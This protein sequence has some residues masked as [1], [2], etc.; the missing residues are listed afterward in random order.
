MTNVS[1]NSSCSLSGEYFMLAN[2]SFTDESN[3]VREDSIPAF[4]KCS[5]FSGS[6]NVNDANNNFRVGS[7]AT[8]NV[9]ASGFRY[10]NGTNLSSANITVIGAYVNQFGTMSPP[11]IYPTNSS[12]TM[13][14]TL[15][16][17]STVFSLYP[18]NFTV[19]NGRW[20][21]SEG[22]VDFKFRVCTG[23][24][25]SI[26][27]R[28]VMIDSSIR[29]WWSSMPG[30][31]QLVPGQPVTLTINAKTNVSN[32][33]GGF[34]SFGVMGSSTAFSVAGKLFDGW[35]SSSHDTA[36]NGYETWEVNVTVPA[37]LRKGGASIV[38]TINSSA[39]GSVGEKATIRTF[40]TTQG[41]TVGIT[42]GDMQMTNTDLRPTTTS[43]NVTLLS[44]GWNFTFIMNNLSGFSDIN[45]SSPVSFRNN[46]TLSSFGSMGQ[47]QVAVDANMSVLILIRNRSASSTHDTILLRNTSMGNSA[48]NISAFTVVNSTN[49]SFN[50]GGLYLWQI[51]SS[52]YLRLV[53]ANASNNGFMSMGI[54]QSTGVQFVIPYIVRQGNAPAVNASINITQIYRETDMGF[55]LG[56]PYTDYTIIAATTDS[57][58]VGF[59]T[60]NISQSG[61]YKLF[62]KVNGS[63]NES[64]SVSNQFMGG[65]GVTTGPTQINIRGFSVTMN[66]MADTLN[67]TVFNITNKSNAAW[68]FFTG[69]GAGSELFNGTMPRFLN[70]SSTLY[71]ALNKTNNETKMNWTQVTQLST[72]SV[73]PCL[74]STTHTLSNTNLDV[75]AFGESW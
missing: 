33:T 40:G 52:S 8:L 7:D 66:F 49:R 13:Q 2:I 6:F 28:G 9:T 51:M 41:A 27:Q 47:Q 14:F 68:N 19:P 54:E 17:G 39:A 62:W 24:V 72:C 44:N 58:G 69:W 22:F 4:F 3:V 16:N 61:R 50:V 64:A 34:E 60:L 53:N 45:L 37:N 31:L 30:S 57:N 35:N 70:S 15:V 10:I 36:A 1:F 75:S 43:D 63:V 38:L 26:F 20:S 71:L 32:I 48:V 23:S 73:S 67:Y 25:C 21:Q 11:E 18:Q 56:S 46:I 12:H 42:Q 55:G 59:V 5:K 29:A 65:G 74:L